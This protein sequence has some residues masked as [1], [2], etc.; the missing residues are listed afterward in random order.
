LLTC[1]E[2]ECFILRGDIVF[3]YIQRGFSDPDEEAKPVR[4]TR[5]IPFDGDI[6]VMVPRWFPVR[7]PSE[8]CSRK[9]NS[10]HSLK[11]HV[12]RAH[13]RQLFF[14]LS[15]GVELDLGLGDCA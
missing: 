14:V 13:N 1:V 7:C 3:A 11:T 5:A 10:P 9:L 8:G 12:A 15:D 2:T 4:K 6:Q